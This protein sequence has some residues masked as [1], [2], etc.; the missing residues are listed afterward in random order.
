MNGVRWPAALALVIALALA[1][2]PTT[3]AD[4]VTVSLQGTT[5]TVTG[6]DGPD[7]IS[8]TSD[9]TNLNVDTNGAPPAEFSVPLTTVITSIVVNAGGGDDT[10]TGGNGLTPRTLIVDGGAG[11]D[12][13]TGG[14][15]GDTL[16]GGDG[17][18]TLIGGRGNDVIQGGAGADQMVW[19]PGD[20]SDTLDGGDGSDRLEFNGANVN[21]MVTLSA[22]GGGIARLTRD[23][24]NITIDMSNME[25]VDLLL[26]GGADT[27]TGGAGLAAV[28]QSVTVSGGAGTDTLNGGDVAETL[29]GG[30]DADLINGGGGDDTIEFSPAQPGDVLNGDGGTNT[31]AITGSDESETYQVDAPGAGQVSVSQSPSGAT[32]LA[33]G[34][35]R[36][37]L[38]ALGGSDTLNLTPAAATAL[39]IDADGGDGN[40]TLNGGRLDDVL[41]GGNGDDVL[42]GNGGN[43]Q[44]FGDAG[45]DLLVGG[46][47]ADAFHCGGVGDVF[48]ATSADT[49][50]PDCL[51]PVAPP[52]P[53][54][55][56]VPTTV[57]T[58][59]TPPP[60]PRLGFSIVRVSATKTTLTVTV[61]DTTTT[62]L[63]IRVAATE[64]GHAYRS[65]THTLKAGAT[66]SFKLS[67]P[68]KVRSALTTALRRAK[69]V[70]RRPAITVTNV[71][72]GGAT[73]T[74]RKL[75]QKR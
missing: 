28:L 13:I 4:G 25:H 5:L 56:T 18:D 10:V 55:V 19:N 46:D 12:T 75:T 73:K 24:A 32:Q 69:S 17:D 7:A 3:S 44:L 38:D 30:A 11:N 57:F 68:A 22:P 49:V 65:V 23:V 60:P 45:D 41:R 47:G 39:Q 2:A 54:T 9:G 21:E 51:P 33:N 50:D 36:V 58:T 70:T 62:A 64:R 34:F 72:T 8:I 16:S 37:H 1:S 42:R 53:L 40:D 66:T 29:A 27:Y 48:D 14:D 26:L 67:T 63:N 59:A 43:D 52:P 20:G 74:T 15:A 71:A 35:Q 31:L 6:T 61:R